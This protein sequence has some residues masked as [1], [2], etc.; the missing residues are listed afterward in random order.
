MA[1]KKQAA[2]ETKSETRNLFAGIEIEGRHRGKYTLFVEGVYPPH[3][4][5]NL[6]ALGE[7]EQVYYG[8]RYKSYDNMPSVFN[9]WNVRA[10][11]VCFDMIHTVEMP[12]DLVKLAEM[13]IGDIENIEF[14]F[15]VPS[16]DFKLITALPRSVLPRVQFKLFFPEGVILIPGEKLS[17][18]SQFE[19]G[20]LNDS[21][22]PEIKV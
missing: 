15:Q 20:L 2:V 18:T 10:N 21:L 9:A 11:A 17:Y 22:L 5:N 16:L 14:V 19:Y 3:I 12:L 4:I 1:N 8:A 13:E 7:Y 6:L